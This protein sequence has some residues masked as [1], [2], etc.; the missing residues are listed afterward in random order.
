MTCTRSSHRFAGWREYVLLAL[1]LASS[2]SGQVHWRG[3]AHNPQHT[4]LSPVPSQCLRQIRWQ[5][6]VDLAPPYSGSSLFIHYGSPLVTP[7]HTVIL[8][9]RTSSSN[10]FRIEARRGWD[11]TLRWQQ[12]TDYVY[13]PYH[14]R[15][16]YGPALTAAGRVYFPGRG[17]TVYYRD[18]VDS[19]SG[20]GGQLAFYGL[21]NYQANTA[22][23][24]GS[25]FINTPITADDA[26]NIYFGFQVT[27]ANPLS[28]VSGLARIDSD[29]TGS[30]VS[31]ATAA[32]D[33]A[34]TK[35]PHNCAPALTEDGDTLYVAVSN[36]TGSG[37][38]ASKG[39]LVR[40]ESQTLA[41]TGRVLL[42]DPDSGLQALIPEDG[43]A[44]PTIGPD[45]DVYYGVLE[46]P[47]PA[48]HDRGWLLHFS[49]D[50]SQTK[51]PGAFGWD[52][53]ASI[54][55]AGLVPSYAGS[56]PYLI[57]TKYNNYAG[58]GIG[59]NVGDGVNRLAV[60]DPHD[61]MVDPVTAAT[62]MKEVLTVVGP[63]PDTQYLSQ[64]PGAVREWCINTAAVDP[65]TRSVLAN[66]SD[67][68]LYRWDL[69]TNTLT[70]SATLTG[71][72]LEAY[73]STLVGVDGTVYATNDAILFAVGT[74]TA[75]DF[76]CDGDADG[77]DLDIFTAC[78]T[79]ANVAPA[80]EC[81]RLDLDHD[82]DVDL[83]DFGRL[84]RCLG[85]PGVTPPAGCADVAD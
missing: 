68:K 67:G 36:G 50:L 18:E 37:F 53:T 14:W 66:S 4:A 75:A 19:A 70:E 63:T 82:G 39:Y 17:G 1:G 7:A 27:G 25:V 79:R 55:L 59:A 20:A 8:P 84:Q 61:T 5:T 62:V 22:A 72:I 29:G 15:L 64:Y 76:D 54:V 52:N 23:F 74:S 26:G 38:A 65:F 56:S 42:R 71:G 28:L 9:V 32:A 57:M 11:G 6:P 77:D 35:V 85:E 49:S 48:N 41:P 73:T 43:T 13:P 69:V 31:A 58:A 44:S 24:N 10:T 83:S 34:M 47:F 33:A 80:A 21:A 2:V 30:W 51:T 46:N 45:G 12:T 3:L 16:S 40:L 60:L 78:A 81:H